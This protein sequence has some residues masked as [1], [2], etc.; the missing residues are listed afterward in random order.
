MSAIR[1]AA[2]TMWRV[3]THAHLGPGYGEFEDYAE[4]VLPVVADIA[5]KQQEYFVCPTKPRSRR[6]GRRG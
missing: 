3:D 2:L 5:G 4:D 1:E 6:R